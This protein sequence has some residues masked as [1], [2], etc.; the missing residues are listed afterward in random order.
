MRNKIYVIAEMSLS[1]Q[2]QCCSIDVGKV[3]A[4]A[5]KNNPDNFKRE[6]QIDSFYYFRQI[7]NSFIT[8][9]KT[10]IVFSNLGIL[11][12]K[13]FALDVPRFFLE[14]AK[15]YQVFILQEQ[16]NIVDGNKL[17]WNI[18]NPENK[19]EFAQGII[20]AINNRGES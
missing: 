1:Q 15:D 4:N 2:E 3:L 12:E 14:Y 7:L 10:R 18:D 8:P 5:Y 17:V 11:L 13:E 16:F 20:E 19:I 6:S 9:D